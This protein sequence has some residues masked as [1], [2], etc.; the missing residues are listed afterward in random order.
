M[1]YLYTVLLVFVVIA[2]LPSFALRIFIT[3]QYKRFREMW[4]FLP[5][6]VLRQVEGR[7]CI[8]VHAVSVGEVVAASP[9]VKEI[10]NLMPNQTI[11]V[12][13]TT[14]TGYTMAKQ[15]IPEAAGI[16]HFPADF[17]WLVN[18]IIRRIQPNL[19]LLVET[20]LWPNFLLAA[21]RHGVKTLMVNGRISD[22]SARQYRYLL[23]IVNGMLNNIDHFYMQSAQDA[24]HIIALGADPARV[25]VTGNTKFD[26]T[27]AVISPPQQDEWKA[28]LGIGQDALVIVAGST[29]KGEEELLIPAFKTLLT[30]FPQSCMVIA[31]RQ[32]KRAAEIIALCRQADLCAISRT[33]IVRNEGGQ[34]AAPCSPHQVVI[35]DT[36]GELGK[37]YGIAD[38]VFVGGSLVPKGGHNILEPA[39]HGKPILVGPHM[40]NFKAIYAELSKRGVCITVG[41]Q[42]ELGVQMNALLKNQELRLWMRR[43]A[44][45]V[46]DENKG[47]SARN[48]QLVKQAVEQVYRERNTV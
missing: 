45:R 31:P 28:M 44:L 30:D 5:E 33:E 4:G 1:Y 15:L 42:D 24:E 47:A 26:Q 41:D 2:M 38:L 11:L 21:K 19:F 34:T 14:T 40:F 39:A 13:V 6:A 8:W 23:R 17:P 32:V 36:I 16:I 18:R 20:E 7:R 10:K 43:E 37:V 35:L 48:A 27:G 22:K 29:H 9:I 12:S 3:G 25:A 46:M